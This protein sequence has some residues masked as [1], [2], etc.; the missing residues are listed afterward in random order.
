MIGRL[1]RVRW[2]DAHG[3]GAGWMPISE[4]D[5]NPRVIESV[6]WVIPD[7]KAGHVVLVASVDDD[8]VDGGL[9]IPHGMI[10]EIVALLDGPRLPLE[11]RTD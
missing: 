10:R 2:H 9:A 8:H 4:I 3:I 5:A 7:V 6:G 11:E 1:V